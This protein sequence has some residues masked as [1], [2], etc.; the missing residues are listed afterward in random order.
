[1]TLVAKHR[2]PHAEMRLTQQSHPD[3]GSAEATHTTKTRHVVVALSG[4]AEADDAVQDDALTVAELMSVR[5]QYENV[6]PPLPDP[7]ALGGLAPGAPA[8]V[9]AYADQE[10]LDAAI[11]KRRKVLSE[12]AASSENGDPNL[13][14]RIG[15]I[16]DEILTAA[17]EVGASLI[18]VGSSERS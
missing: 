8:V 14:V 13:Q 18:I 12:I 17:D 5:L 10:H 9:P 15:L 4:D 6:I 11:E 1:M 3:Q 16:D 2:P 7:A